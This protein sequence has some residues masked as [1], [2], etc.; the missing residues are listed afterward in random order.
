MCDRVSSLRRLR[1]LGQGCLTVL[2]LAVYKVRSSS[3]ADGKQGRK[4]NTKKLLI[5]VTIHLRRLYYL[6]RQKIKNERLNL[7][8]RKS[9]H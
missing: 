7:S 2:L 8:I 9:W 4:P 3:I 6:K 1:G 5:N